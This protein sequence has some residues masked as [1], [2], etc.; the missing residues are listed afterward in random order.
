[1]KLNHVVALLALGVVALTSS[2]APA[3]DAAPSPCAVS[4]LTIEQLIEQLDD[5]DFRTRVSATEALVKR[6]AESLEKIGKVFSRSS[7]ETQARLFSVLEALFK[8]K[9]TQEQARNILE[10]LVKSKSSFAESA[11][12]LIGMMV[13]YEV[14]EWGVFTI[15]ENAEWANAEMTH[16]WS[17]LPKDIYRS[18]PAWSNLPNVW[19]G[20]VTKPVIYFY[21][22]KVKRKAKFQ[23]GFRLEI[24]FTEGRHAVW[25][26]VASNL[27]NATGVPPGTIKN[28]TDEIHWEYTFRNSRGVEGNIFEQLKVADNHWYAKLRQVKS[29]PVYAVNP[30]WKY[31]GGGRIR[32]R[33]SKL[34]K[35][36][37]LRRRQKRKVLKG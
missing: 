13:G 17:T 35:K 3:D 4:K 27:I 36:K 9:E 23:D 24:R 25:Y 22:D 7:A 21:T 30:E 33:T 11:S 29:N 8:H 19:H 15:F 16:E 26:P 5:D 20:P 32:D 28:A 10:H 14:H 2:T 1:M 31:G 37:S 12:E 34:Q 18:L 6:G